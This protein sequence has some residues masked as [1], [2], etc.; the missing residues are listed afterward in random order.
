[1]LQS[2]LST[3]IG[4]FKHKLLPPAQRYFT[5]VFIIL[6]IIWLVSANYY[7]FADEANKSLGAGTSGILFLLMALITSM[8]E[9]HKTKVE[10]KENITHELILKTLPLLTPI[11][12]SIAKNVIFN[13]KIIKLAVFGSIAYFVS[14]LLLT[15]KNK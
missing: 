5:Y 4:G 2:I 9:K 15:R 7:Y 11:I 13:R 8:W 14:N 12:L 3:I 1:M 6:G 10:T